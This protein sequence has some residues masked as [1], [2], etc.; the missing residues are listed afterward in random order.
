MRSFCTYIDRMSELSRKLRLHLEHQVWFQRLPN[1][2]S[3]W[4][5]LDYQRK[6]IKDQSMYGNSLPDGDENDR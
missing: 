5:L 1:Q 3:V 4:V 6:T 2:F